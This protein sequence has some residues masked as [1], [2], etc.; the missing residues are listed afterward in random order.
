MRVCDKCEIKQIYTTFV[1]KRDNSEFDMC[2]ECYA[3]LSDW[4]YKIERKKENDPVVDAP[5]I[6]DKP[7]KEVR[8]R[9]K[10]TKR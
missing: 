2:N 5:V 6:I 3:L 8:K 9:G 10:R 1:N 4:M 7:I